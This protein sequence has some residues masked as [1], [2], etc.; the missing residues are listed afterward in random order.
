MGFLQLA[1]SRPIGLTEPDYRLRYW[2]GCITACDQKT[3]AQTAWQ[4]SGHVQRAVDH[5]DIIQHEIDHDE[6][7]KQA[8]H[9]PHA[10]RKHVRQPLH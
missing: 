9:H 3:P 5:R 2:S 7:D 8:D 4:L 6:G 10:F 1:F